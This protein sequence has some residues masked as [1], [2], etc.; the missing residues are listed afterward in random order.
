MVT[1]LRI[2]ADLV[3]RISR[4]SAPVY[5]VIRNGKI[6]WRSTAISAARVAA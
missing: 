2:N 6:I 1:E 5:E 3:V 4:Q